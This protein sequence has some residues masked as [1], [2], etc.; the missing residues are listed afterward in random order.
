MEITLQDVLNMFLDRDG[1]NKVYQT[2]A[3][4]I[5]YLSKENKF[6][7]TT[8]LGVSKIDFDGV[9]DILKKEYKQNE[10]YYKEEYKK[11]CPFRN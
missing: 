3:M 7:L 2:S 5:D 1:T 6:Y 4:V 8:L 9:I 10:K 11:I